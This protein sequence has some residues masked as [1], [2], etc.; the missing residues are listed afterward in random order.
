VAGGLGPLDLGAP[1]PGCDGAGPADMVG[2]GWEEG[3]GYM[4][5]MGKLSG[6]VF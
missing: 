3:L 1:A 2:L 4:K 5:V 6:L